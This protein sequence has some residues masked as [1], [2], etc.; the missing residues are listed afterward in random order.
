TERFLEGD[1]DFS[2]EEILGALRKGVLAHQ[3]VPVTCGS[4]FKN[5]GVQ[6]L[7]D[8]VVSFLPSPI[9]VPAIQGVKPNTGSEDSAPE[10]LERH[11]D[12]EEPFSAL[13]FKI[14]NDPFVG[15]LTFLRAYS[16]VLK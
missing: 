7:L 11:A 5:K 2:Y 13:A 16:G 1:A 3:I 10:K 6:F 12:P 4:A 15:Q 14:V 9:D 8:A